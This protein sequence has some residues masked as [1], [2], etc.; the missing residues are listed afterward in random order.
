MKTADGE[1]GGYAAMPDRFILDIS[2]ADQGEP[3]TVR[4]LEGEHGL[5]EA[6]CRRFMHDAMRHETMRPEADR[7]FRNSELRLESFANTGPARG[8]MRPGKEGQDRAGVTG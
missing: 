5:A 4:I 8:R 3:H 1:F 6:L 7:A 2:R